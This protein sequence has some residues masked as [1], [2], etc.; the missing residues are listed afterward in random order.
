MNEAAASETSFIP[1]S[2]L[3]QVHG[4]FQTYFFSECDLV[5]PLSIYNIHSFPSGKAAVYAFFLV[6]PS[7]IHFRSIICFR[8]QFLRK[9]WPIHISFVHFIVCWMYSFSFTQRNT[10]S[11]LTT[12]VHMIF[13]RLYGVKLQN[14]E[15]FKLTVVYISVVG[16]K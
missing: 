16:K 6:L 11:F 9:T 10:S 2:V 15:I 4:L 3:R 13:S 5:R 12:S 7:L 14:T 8:R 1:Q